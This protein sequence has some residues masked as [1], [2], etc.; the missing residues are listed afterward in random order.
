[1]R[2]AIAPTASSLAETQRW[3]R[4]NVA[5]HPRDRS[6]CR[7]IR[8]LLCLLWPLGEWADNAHTVW[9]SRKSRAGS[10]ARVPLACRTFLRLLAQRILDR[11]R[12]FVLSRDTA[13][14][15]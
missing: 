6:E 12:E 11:C 8:R 14:Q 1:M 2:L 7:P 10:N 15:M 13:Q 5:H 3:L 4:A 9:D